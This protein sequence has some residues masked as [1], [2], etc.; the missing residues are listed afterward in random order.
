M[1]SGVVLRGRYQLLRLLGRGG[2]AEVYLA[3]DTMRQ[4]E[5]AVKILREDLAEDPQFLQRFQREAEALSRLDHPNVVRFYSFE[6]QGSTAFIVMDYV[7][8]TTL[9]GR[10]SEAGEAL[11]IEEITAILKQV[12][13]ALYYAHSQG[14]IHRDIKPGNIMLRDDGRALLSDLGIARAT[15]TS[16]MTMGPLGTPAYMSPEQILGRAVDAR[17]DVYSLGIVLYEM[18]TGHRPFSGDMGTGTSTA[19]RVRDEHLHMLPQDPRRLNPALPEGAARVIQK[20]LAKDPA[21]RWQDAIALAKAW[22]QAV[23]QEARFSAAPTVV[24][25]VPSRPITPPRREPTT[26]PV[27][28]TQQWSGATGTRAWQQA[29]PPPVKK[30]RRGWVLWAVLGGGAVLILGGIACAVVLSSVLSNSGTPTAVAIATVIGQP[31][32]VAGG[33]TPVAT[34]TAEPATPTATA[35]ASA[36]V[37]RADGSGDY[38]SLTAAVSAA[39]VGATIRL[40]PG[41]YALDSTL[42]VTKALALVGAGVDQTEV[43]SQAADSVIDVTLDGLFTAEGISF[44]HEGAEI[45]SVALVAQGTAEFRNCRFSGAVWDSEAERGGSGVVFMN[46]ASGLVSQSRADANQLYGIEV[47]GNAYAQIDGNVSVD[48]GGGGISLWGDASADVTNNVCSTNGYHGIALNGQATANVTGNTC[49]KNQYSGISYFNDG[50]GTASRN[51]CNANGYHGIAVEGNAQPTLEDNVCVGNTYSGISYFGA[52]AGLARGNQV[53]Q[54]QYHGIGVNGSAAP[55]LEGNQCFDNGIHGIGVYDEAAPVVVGNTC[56]NNKDSGITFLGNSRG[57]ASGN[58]CS[59]NTLHGIAVGDTATPDLTE[60]IC[61]ENADSGIAYFGTAAGSA[62]AN[63]AYGNQVYGIYVEGT[64]N[65]VLQDNN[66]HDNLTQD[67]LD[68]RK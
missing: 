47:I 60:N 29:A 2:M 54:N 9:R 36:I 66:A 14:Y 64:A 38:P 5:V 43:V 7:P 42:S 57:T 4:T 68:Q 8:G 10:L 55:R 49:E 62:S 46:N 18:S 1:D 48:N 31:S 58:Q 17:T 50:G 12:T 41:S 26:P 24:G 53:S 11:P 13:S 59:G 16:T 3:L 32:P 22:V 34:S 25:P 27:A 39:A 52:A 61:F 56:G 37:V 21:E 20:A 44:R 23:E 40:E 19:D 15:E 35:N 63:E 67:V 28:Q 6:R 45:A 33:V 51:N 65:P 30:E